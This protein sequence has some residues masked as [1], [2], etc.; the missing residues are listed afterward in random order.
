MPD[1]FANTDRTR[2]VELWNGAG[3]RTRVVS[4]LGARFWLPEGWVPRRHGN[5]ILAGPAHDDPACGP[6]F[7]PFQFFSAPAQ[8]D[9]L[10]S[11][12]R[13]YLAT[14]RAAGAQIQRRHVI[15]RPR[16]ALLVDYELPIREGLVRSRLLGQLIDN[17]TAS[18][19]VTCSDWS[20]ADRNLAN[21]AAA[22]AMNIWRALHLAP[23]GLPNGYRRIVHEA[24]RV[25]FACPS[26]WQ[27][28]LCGETVYAFRAPSRERSDPNLTVQI[29]TTPSHPRSLRDMTAR[30]P[31][32]A[33]VWQPARVGSRCGLSADFSRPDRRNQ[34]EI[35]REL[36]PGP[37]EHAAL[38]IQL[39]GAPADTAVL[40]AIQASFVWST[41][42]S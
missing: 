34:L 36:L 41:A 13:T 17:G 20:T 5:K 25:Q 26:Q 39:S 11:L 42:D 35:V 24:A 6:P 12:E 30:L 8:A 31:E 14:L 27:I 22:W 37:D 38:F 1:D 2:P 16:P 21:G 3:L 19:C 9:N 4:A 29:D 28:D 10:R 40:N 7:A 32:R 33:Q 23:P 15:E 18:V